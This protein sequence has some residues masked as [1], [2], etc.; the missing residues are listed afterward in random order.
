MVSLLGGPL[1]GAMGMS[2]V[3]PMMA[4]MG[5]QPQMYQL[6]GQPQQS[7]VAQVGTP[8]ILYIVEV[9]FI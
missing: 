9:N 7:Y 8:T 6:V 3:N 5:N 1:D 4:E 2:Q